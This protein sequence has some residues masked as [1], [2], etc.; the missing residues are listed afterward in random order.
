MYVI[1]YPALVFRDRMRLLIVWGRGA[2]GDQVSG[3]LKLPVQ[4]GRTPAQ[5]RGALSN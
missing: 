3:V 2:H 4:R 1:L 5:W